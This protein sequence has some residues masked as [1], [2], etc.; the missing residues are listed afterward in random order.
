MANQIM[1]AATMATAGV[2]DTAPFDERIKETQT[3]VAEPSRLRANLLDEVSRFL[4]TLGVRAAQNHLVYCLEQWIAPPHG[5]VV[6]R[7]GLS[8]SG[9][10][11]TPTDG[12]RHIRPKRAIGG[13][14]NL[15]PVL[16]D[17][18]SENVRPATLA[19]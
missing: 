3:I 8:H 16:V 19:K 9:D 15:K 10:A 7:P 12:C 17:G 1:R 11:S 14:V 18:G 4:I 2:A 13:F 6:R 5:L